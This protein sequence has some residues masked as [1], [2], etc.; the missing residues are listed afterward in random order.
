MADGYVGGQ[1]HV[2]QAIIEFNVVASTELAEGLPPVVGNRFTNHPDTGVV[3]KGLNF[4]D[5]HQRLEIPV[6]L[7]EPWSEV[8]NPIS[9]I[10]RGDFRAQHVCV[11]DIIL[12]GGIFAYR[13]DGKLP[14]LLG[15]KQAP[16]NKRTVKR[17]PAKPGYV[18]VFLNVGQVSTISNDSTVVD[19]S[20]F[21]VYMIVR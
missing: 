3:V 1:S 11:L 5:E 13:T 7:P 4:S 18:G 17:R 6:V 14:P 16:E 20:F 21:H 15:I 8:S 2:L 10:C 19:V 9:S 12:M